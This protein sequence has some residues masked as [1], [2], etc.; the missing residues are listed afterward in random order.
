MNYRNTDR[1]LNKIRK[2]MHKQNEKFNKEIKNQN[3][4]TKKLLTNPRAEK[5]RKLTEEL[6]R[7][8]QKQTWACRKKPVTYKAEH[9]KFSSQRSKKKEGW[10]RIKKAYETYGTQ[11]NTHTHIISALQKFWKEKRKRKGQSIFK[12]IIAENSQIWGNRRTSRYLRPK[13]SQIG[14]TWIGLHCDTLY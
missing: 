1:Y 5:Y 14:L 7:E 2:T 12:A 6:N 10:K 11:K 13:G 3:K 8:L 4:Q 9:L